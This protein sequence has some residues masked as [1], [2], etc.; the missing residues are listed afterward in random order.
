[1]KPTRKVIRMLPLVLHHLR[2]HQEPPCPP[3]LHKE[4]WRTCRVL[5]GF[6]MLDFDEIFRASSEGWHMSYDTFSRLSGNLHVLQDSMKELWGQVESWQGSWCWILMKFS[7]QLNMIDT[8]H[9]TLSPGLSRV[10]ISSKTPG[11]DMEDG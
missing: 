3:R 2:V 8:C 5:I 6:F 10:Y 4:A 11:R 9:M 1:M 7:Q